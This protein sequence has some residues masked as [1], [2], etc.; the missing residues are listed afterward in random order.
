ED[1]GEEVEGL[2]AG[3]F[4][5]QQAG[6]NS[7]GIASRAALQFLLRRAALPSRTLRAFPCYETD[8]RGA[9]GNMGQQFDRHNDHLPQRG[10]FEQR[11]LAE[12]P[13]QELETAA[14]VLA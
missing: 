4:K 14:N 1:K 8:A 2:S 6:D 10:F 12:P 13:Y 5:S 11:V 9:R 7:F 3:N